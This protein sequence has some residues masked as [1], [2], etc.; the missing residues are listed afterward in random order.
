MRRWAWLAVVALLVGAELLS[1]HS[2]A[3][4]KE[5]PS[6]PTAV[7]QPPRVT[8]AGLRGKPALVDFWASWCGPCAEEAPQL[9]RAARALR[10]RGRIVAVDWDDDGADARAFVSH[11]GWTFPVLADSDGATGER[12]GLIGLPT[13]FVLDSA[14]QIVATLRGPQSAARL[15]RVVLNAG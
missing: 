12:Y 4:A 5:A 7:L 6:L 1:G 10:G 11:H 13:A 9:R 8:L 14:G 15:R 2:P 3:G